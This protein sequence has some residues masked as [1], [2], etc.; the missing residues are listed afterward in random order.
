M[1]VTTKSR[2]TLF[3][4]LW[5]S[6]RY[7]EYWLYSTWLKMG[8]QYRKT[9]LG[10]IWLMVSPAMFII[11]LGYLFAQVG[12]RSLAVFVPH[13]AVGYI[14]WTLVS[15]IVT[16]GTT[17]FHRRRSELLQGDIRLTDLVLSNFFSTFLQFLHQIPV[18]I[19]VMIW[20]KIMPTASGVL[21]SLFGLCLIVINGIWM[22]II[23]GIIGTHYRDL[24]EIISAFMRLAFFITPIIWMDD[25]GAG[26]LL[27]AYLIF[28]PFFHFLDIV[29]A[30]LLGDTIMVATWIFV[31]LSTCIGGIFAAALYR[32]QARSIAMWV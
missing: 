31:A 5:H 25:G 26:G 8:L 14:T 20:F 7:R 11:M 29:R 3:K 22:I 1:I 30:P 12:G 13:L 21:M 4:D 15:G 18:I 10:P 17:L 9:T 23:A 24:A 27:G 16:N 32:F 28:N 2:S 6:I 19:A